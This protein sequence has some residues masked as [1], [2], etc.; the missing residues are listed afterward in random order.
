MSNK[1]LNCQSI[2]NQLVTCSSGGYYHGKWNQHQTKFKIRCPYCQQDVPGKK[3][4][5]SSD[6]TAALL[7]KMVGTYEVWTFNCMKCKTKKSIDD[8]VKDHPGLITPNNPLAKI[9]LP[10][11]AT[12]PQHHQSPKTTTQESSVKKNGITRCRTLSP[13]EQAGYGGYLD[14]LVAQ[15]KSAQKGMDL[16]D[17][18][19]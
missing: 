19:K 7:L 17:F 3:R 9:A 13:Q 14:S 11:V 2:M 4:F 6:H 16:L 18:M 1:N 8:L 12:L 5:K 10:D 15:R